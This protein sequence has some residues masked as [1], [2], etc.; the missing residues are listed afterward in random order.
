MKRLRSVMPAFPR[1]RLG[2]PN[3]H[4]PLRGRRLADD[5]GYSLEL[6][7]RAVRVI[8]ELAERTRSTPDQALIESV[9]LYKMTLDS[10]GEPP[11]AE[12]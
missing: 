11:P 7:P 8:N 5:A 10:F 9:N 2:G 6:S 1:K 3:R 12:G 4:L